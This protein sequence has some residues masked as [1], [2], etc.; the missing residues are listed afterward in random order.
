MIKR[1]LV[2][3]LLAISACQAL[4][5]DPRPGIYSCDSEMATGD[6]VLSKRG[7]NFQVEGKAVFKKTS[8][9][10]KGTLFSATGKFKGTTVTRYRTG[11]AFEGTANGSWHDATDTLTIATSEGQFDFARK[12][13]SFEGVWKCPQFGTLTIRQIGD[14]ISGTYGY[15]FNTGESNTGRI[16]GTVKGGRATFEWHEKSSK[17]QTQGKGWFDLDASGNSFT[18]G[19]TYSGSEPLGKSGP[20]TGKRVK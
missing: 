4:A 9:A 17:R 10:I 5:D 16:E 14:E 7:P 20:W 3:L 12:R 19:W 18:G 2:A 8:V 1:I 11:D 13:E 6:V 15:K